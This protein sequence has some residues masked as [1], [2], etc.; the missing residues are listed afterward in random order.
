MRRLRRSA[1]PGLLP[2][3]STLIVLGG[4]SSLG[5]LTRGSLA[6]AQPRLPVDVLWSAPPPCPP[7]SDVEEEVV[8]TI[9]G[10][11]VGKERLRARVDVWLSEGGGWKADIE[12]SSSGQITKRQ[13]QGDSCTIVARAVAVVVGVAA[14][15][16]APPSLGAA[17]S[18]SPGSEGLADAA[19]PAASTPSTSPIPAVFAPQVPVEIP[20]SAST[21]PPPPPPVTRPS[22]PVGLLV[23]ASAIFDVGSLPALSPG[24]E[25]FAGWAP[26]WWSLETVGTILAAESAPLVPGPANRH[27]GASLWRA[28]L[29]GRACG[30]WRARLLEVGPCI[31]ANASWIR[32]SGFG[33]E[34]NSSPTTLTGEAVVGARLSL[35]VTRWAALHMG[36]NLVLPFDRPTFLIDN[37]GDVYHPSV[38]AFRGAL[39]AEGHF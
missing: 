23:G 22:R 34:M 33:A 19:P 14:I 2:S 31:G 24:V 15:E 5:V 21:P 39:G 36:A 28:E 27:E 1:K 20:T 16:D 6:E 7:Q 32:A 12:L 38:A 17:A 13:V 37:E 11:P 4:F 9:A 18:D 35:H 10:R 25:V 8:R 26:T 30:S 29:G 3:L